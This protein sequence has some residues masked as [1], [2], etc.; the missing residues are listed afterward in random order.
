MTANEFHQFMSQFQNEAVALTFDQIGDS[1]DNVAP[2]QVCILT[3]KE[4]YD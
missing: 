2:T 1:L 4:Q 3:K